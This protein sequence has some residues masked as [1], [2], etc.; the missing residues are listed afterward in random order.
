MPVITRS[1]TAAAV[2]LST[3]QG[4]KT[5]SMTRVTNTQMDSIMD[6]LTFYVTR[7]LER[8]RETDHF[9][10][11]KKIIERSRLFDEMY[12]NIGVVFYPA[13]KPSLVKTQSKKLVNQWKRFIHVIC[14]KVDDLTFEIYY[15]MYDI[16][17][18]DSCHFSREERAYLDMV[19]DNMKKIKKQLEDF[20]VYPEK[21]G[22]W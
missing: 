11:K 18:D 9:H 15:E 5:R 17:E 14:D 3:S 6:W 1:Q 2:P 12:Y 16:D 20:L 21:P 4:M 10:M 22:R 13:M 8:Y 7:T 19:I